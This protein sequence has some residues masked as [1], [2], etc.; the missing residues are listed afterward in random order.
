[1]KKS[2]KTGSRLL[3]I[4]IVIVLGV[5]VW[6]LIDEEKSIEVKVLAIL[7]LMFLSVILRAR[8]HMSNLGSTNW[9]PDMIIWIDEILDGW[10]KKNRDPP[11]FYRSYLY[12]V[13]KAQRF[14]D[15]TQSNDSCRLREAISGIK[16]CLDRANLCY[17]KNRREDCKVALRSALDHARRIY[18]Y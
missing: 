5:A 9:I 18:V 2:E 7:A 12:F 13:G 11:N 14:L 8:Y 10:D 3:F 1:M 16:I 6:V 4:V 15:K 17:L